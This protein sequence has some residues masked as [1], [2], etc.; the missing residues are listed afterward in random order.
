[1]AGLTMLTITP[2][3]VQAMCAYVNH[4]D[5]EGLR[6]MLW[7]RGFVVPPSGSSEVE[8]FRNVALY[9]H[10][11]AAL[12]LHWLANPKDHIADK[13]RVAELLN[14]HAGHYTRLFSAFTP[15]PNVTAQFKVGHQF[16]H[17]IDLVC[18]YVGEQLAYRGDIAS[19]ET[20]SSIRA[21]RFC[22]NLFARHRK[23]RFCP[24]G[25]CR[26]KSYY[27][28]GPQ[29]ADAFYMFKRRILSKKLKPQML[30][31]AVTMGIERVRRSKLMKA[32]E[33]RRRIR[34]LKSL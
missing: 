26:M 34:F 33:K 27:N 21:C 20:G 6:R 15:F 22:G 24:G 13:E 3:E 23:S 31:K 19:A 18:A 17:L 28:K 14:E 30:R 2:A 10:D 5:T 32:A 12:L 4:G 25:K 1:M 29:R 8:N 11:D 9:Y 7:K 16:S